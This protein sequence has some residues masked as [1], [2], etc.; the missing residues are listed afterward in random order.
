M[1]IKFRVKN[2][3]DEEDVEVLKARFSDFIKQAGGAVAVANFADMPIGTLKSTL[4]DPNRCVS[5]MLADSLCN[6]FAADVDNKFTREH[7]RPDVTRAQ[8]ARL[9][10]IKKGA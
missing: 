8:W 10:R 5:P 4:G 1:R 3:L 7:L 9:D 2:N 6:L